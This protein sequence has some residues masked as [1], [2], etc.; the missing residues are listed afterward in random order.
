MTAA[1]N[2][3]EM[4]FHVRPKNFSLKLKWEVSGFATSVGIAIQNLPDE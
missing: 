4:C 1:E 3:Y 2:I